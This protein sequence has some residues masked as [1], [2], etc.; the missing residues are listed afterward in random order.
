MDCQ[1]CIK[2]YE[3]RACDPKTVKFKHGC[4]VYCYKEYNLI[5]SLY[6][7]KLPASQSEAMETKS[8]GNAQQDIFASDYSSKIHPYCI[9]L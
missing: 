8:N 6:G 4:I 2:S 9:Y 5:T 7:R 3:Q 1:E